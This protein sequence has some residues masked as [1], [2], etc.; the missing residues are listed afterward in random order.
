MME[1][2]SFAF[3]QEKFWICD[4]SAW[5]RTGFGL[6]EPSPWKEHLAPTVLNIHCRN[7]NSKMAGSVGSAEKQKENHCET[8]SLRLAV[9]IAF[10]FSSLRT[11][12][13]GRQDPDRFTCGRRALYPTSGAEKR[14]LKRGG[15]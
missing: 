12:S 15:I 4:P 2:R 13:G 5:L 10:W 6:G 1:L 3:A 8:F 7:R 14:V 11:G 9:A